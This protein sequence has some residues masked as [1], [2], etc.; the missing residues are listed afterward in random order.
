MPDEVADPRAD[1]ELI[2][3]TAAGDRDAFGVIVARHHGA[4]FRIARAL[5]RDPQAAEDVLQETFLAA[6]RG[7]A[8]YRGDA[9]VASWLYA[10][11]RHAAYRLSRRASEVAADED[12]LE[13]LG[14]AAGWGQGDVEVA[15][16]RAE[17]RARIAAAMDRLPEEERAVI[18]LRDAL[19]A[20]GEQAA[21]AL[22]VSVAAMKSRLHRG[23]LRLAGLLRGSGGAHVDR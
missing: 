23:R 11:A 9:P 16:A 17:E 10:I 14:L 18:V 20:T 15:A 5:T 3:A 12:S 6:L 8:G 21:A 2:A 13:R 22:G 7:A 19:G 1:G 4:V